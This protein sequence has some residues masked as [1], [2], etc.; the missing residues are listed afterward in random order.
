MDDK[1]RYDR[2]MELLARVDGESGE[3][4]LRALDELCPDL[5]RYVVEFAFGEVYQ[6]PGLDL[7][8]RELITVAALTTLRATPQLTV[9]VNGALN[10][11]CTRREV[12]ETILHMAV[13]AGFPAAIT[14]MFTAREVFAE[15]DAQGRG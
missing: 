2:G 4:V 9:H 1:E 10:V 5:G 14:G 11:G 6:R 15:R 8:T 12:L 3:K 7:R 13:Y